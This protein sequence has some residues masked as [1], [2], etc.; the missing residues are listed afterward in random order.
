M[1]ESTKTKAQMRNGA[2]EIEIW[3]I[4]DGGKWLIVTKWGMYYVWWV[5]IG[6]VVNCG[7]EMEERGKSQKGD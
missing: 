2:K 6:V 3:E 5:G 7:M 1:N 4:R